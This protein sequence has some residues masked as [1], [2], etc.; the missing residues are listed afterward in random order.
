MGSPDPSGRGLRAATVDGIFYPA[1]PEILEARLA[2]LLAEAA[3]PQPD[4]RT[5]ALITPHAALDCAGAVAAAAFRS[6]CTRRP[7]TVVLL[8]PMHRDA[9]E[10]V[11][12]PESAAFQT[13]LGRARVDRQALGELQA[14]TGDWLRADDIPHL[15]EHC[16][17]VQLPF[18][19]H[20]FP[21]LSIVPL[22]VGRPSR[23]LVEGLAR[24]LWETFGTRLDSTLFVATANLGGSPARRRRLLRHVLAADWRWFS[25]QRRKACTCGSGALAAILAL[26]GRR[27][28]A[29]T[30]LRQGCARA[31]SDR[32][33]HYAAVALAE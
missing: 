18:L 23:P 19:Q 32:T 16:L 30:L 15:E 17:E 29:V 9:P 3:L 14:T 11:V 31:G 20:L 10:A 5:Y 22:L 13:P 28:G 2:Q 26:H 33:V 21:R 8:G 27:G 6:V 4:A 7:T 12:A 1:E 25:R 24:G